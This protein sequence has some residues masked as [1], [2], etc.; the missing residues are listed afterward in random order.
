MRNAEAVKMQP[1]TNACVLLAISC[2]LSSVRN[3]FSIL[4]TPLDCFVL[5]GVLPRRK[6][7]ASCRR[8][9]RKLSPIQQYFHQQESEIEKNL[10][11]ARPLVEEW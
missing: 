9:L 11:K 10:S 2:L 8:T 1:P 5:K 7:P 4:G 6:I 3:S